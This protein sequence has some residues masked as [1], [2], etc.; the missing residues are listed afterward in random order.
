M[1]QT[2]RTTHRPKKTSLNRF[3]QLRGNGPVKTQVTRLTSSVLSHRVFHSPFQCRPKIEIRRSRLL[4]IY[5]GKSVQYPFWGRLALCSCV[6]LF[7]MHRSLS[8]C[9]LQ[10]IGELF[11]RRVRHAKGRD[12]VTGTTVWFQ[13]VADSEGPTSLLLG[14]DS[15]PV[16]FGGQIVNAL[17]HGDRIKASNMLSNFTAGTSVRNEDDLLFVLD[18][19]AKSPDPLFVMEMWRILEEKHITLGDKSCLLMVRALCRGGYLDEAFQL[20]KFL[21]ENHR[22]SYILPLY[23]QYLSACVKMQNVIHTNQCL[24]LMDSKLVGKNEVTYAVLLKLAVWQQN[25]LAVHN[26]WKEYIQYYNLNMISLRKFIWTFTRLKDLDSAY[27]TLQHMVALV[28]EKGSSLKINVEGKISCC[29][30]DIP[31]PLKDSHMKKDD[32]IIHELPVALVFDPVVDSQESGAQELAAFDDE[33]KISGMVTYGML[34][35]QRSMPVKKVLRW[36]FNDVIHGCAQARNSLLAEKLFLQVENFQ[37]HCSSRSGF[38]HVFCYCS[39]DSIA[40]GDCGGGFLLMQS[41]GLDP[42]CHTYDGFIRATV[43]GKGVGDGIELVKKMEKHNLKPYSSTLATLAISCSRGLEL[44]LAEALLNQMSESPYPLPY[45]AFLEACDTLDQPERAVRMLAKMVNLKVKPDIRT[46]ELLFSLFG[47][48]NAPYEEGNML[49]QVDVSK[50]IKAI[51]MDMM[52]NGVQHSQISMKNLLKALGSEGMIGDLMEYLHRAEQ[53]FSQQNTYVGL[54]IYNAVL[55]SLV[56]GGESH[57]AIQIFKNLRLCGFSP[58]HIM[59]TIMINCCVDIRSF[60]SACALLSLMVQ[61]GY[62]PNT[63]AYTSLIQILLECNDFDGALYLLDQAI[64]E[65]NEPDVLLFNVILNKACFKGRIDV[66][67]YVIERMHQEEVQPDPSTCSYVFTAYTESEYFSTAI[68]ALQVLSMRMIS[69]DENILQEKMMEFE[70]D[71]VFAEDPKAELRIIQ[72][73]H[74]SSANVAAALLNLR[75]CATLGSSIS[76]NPDESLWAKRLASNHGM[77]QRLAAQ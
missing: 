52:K 22:V 77:R 19:C 7:E 55:H 37:L 14:G 73:F 41:L 69:L 35:H 43:R 21:G 58:N 12:K 18:Y 2:Q 67:E 44:G 46:Y 60:K 48:V 54:S 39:L 38:Y 56:E 68:E 51:E 34:T 66:I 6:V 28:M 25:L 23:N 50:R 15:F 65:G 40:F 26:I 10:Y 9:P 33:G 72:I 47:N 3:Y 31:V 74:E 13:T 32:L 62:Y 45:N 75:W 29:H 5:H 24:E 20:L 63:L 11:S 36:S 17:R 27:K 8:R 64:S 70:E 59:Y 4:F 76:L 49:S 1:F 71:F 42:S 61:A 57:K 53:L 30:L 16:S